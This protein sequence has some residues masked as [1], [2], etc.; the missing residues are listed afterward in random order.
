LIVFA[1]DFYRNGSSL[2][3]KK[4]YPQDVKLIINLEA[5][6][7]SENLDNHPTKICLRNNIET[8]K[9]LI[10]SYSCV[11]NLSN[12]HILDFGA[13]GLVETQEHLAKIGA[14]YFGA[15]DSNVTMGHIYYCDKDNTCVLSYVQPSANP[16]YADGD[17][18]LREATVERVLA[19]AEYCRSA[20]GNDVGIILSIHAGYEEVQIP[21]PARVT[22]TKRLIDSVELKGIIFH[23][24]HVIQPAIFINGCA[25]FFSIGNFAFDE[26]EYINSDGKT[27][28]GSPFPWN[29]AGLL[30]EYDAGEFK[31]SRSYY[32][33][34]I[35]AVKSTKHRY[36]FFWHSILLSPLYAK[37][38]T[39]I[40]RYSMLKNSIARFIVRPKMPSMKAIIHLFA[41]K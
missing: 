33:S 23:H 9:N 41:G 38:Y 28:W 27:S 19:D 36:S 2:D 37:L 13:A 14:E 3:I 31:W 10:D 21:E 18:S 6:I 16:V 5:P 11:F 29:R 15:C 30:I 26:F 39:I 4:S 24:P 12:N 32:K 17:M 40:Y 35:V 20:Y 34:G 8:A 22:F 25:V 1:G 7:C